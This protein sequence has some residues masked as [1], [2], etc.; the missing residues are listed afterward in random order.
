MAP[1]A[2]W[3]SC[4]PGRAAI[5]VRLAGWGARLGGLPSIATAFWVFFFVFNLGH[6]SLIFCLGFLS[7]SKLVASV[8]FSLEMS[9]C[10]SFWPK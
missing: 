3:A 4:R 10:G 1:E 8:G 9:W 6:H 5:S 2:P 7:K